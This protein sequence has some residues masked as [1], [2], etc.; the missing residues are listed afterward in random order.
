MHH[1][2]F[3]EVG[4]LSHIVG[5]VEFGWVDFIDIVGVNISFLENFRLEAVEA[6]CTSPDRKQISGLHTVPSSHRTV[7][8]PSS[9][10]TTSPFTN[11]FS[12]SLTH[13]HRLPE[14]SLF[15]PAIPAPKFAE[16]FR[17]PSAALI[18]PG[19]KVPG[20]PFVAE[21]LLLCRVLATSAEPGR[22][23]GGVGL[24]LGLGLGDSAAVKADTDCRWPLIPGVGEATSSDGG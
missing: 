14:K 9:S 8:I 6:N 13:T 4:Q 3:I 17:L 11:A 22:E 19:A 23:V 1:G 5:F 16:L 10:S 2:S 12:G 15:S 24:G 20:K 7:S 21:L 18:N